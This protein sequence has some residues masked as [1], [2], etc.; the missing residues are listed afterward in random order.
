M[1]IDATETKRSVIKMVSRLLQ[2][3]MVTPNPGYS[4][5]SDSRAPNQLETTHGCCDGRHRAPI[6]FPL[7]LEAD[8]RARQLADES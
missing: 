7:G 2:T 6:A 3:G 5:P 1:K 4:N 8:T